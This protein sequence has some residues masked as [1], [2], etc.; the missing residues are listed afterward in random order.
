MDRK[1]LMVFADVTR[2]VTV[3]GLLFLN[4]TDRLWIAYAVPAVESALAS[5][6]EPASMAAIPN[7]VAPEDLATA[8]ALAGSAWGT[9]LAVGAALGAIVAATLG[10][11]AAF[12]ADS[13]SFVISAIL[14]SSIRTSLSEAATLG[15]E[16]IGVV[17]ATAETIRYA[18]EDHRVL[19]LIAVKGGFGL[20]GGVIVLL[21]VLGTKVFH[22]GDIGI[23][24]LM[25]AR[26][27]GALIG[28]FIGKRI[29][30]NEFGK[31]LFLAIGLALVTFGFFYML[32]PFAPS[33]ALAAVCAAGAHLGGGAQWSLSTFGLQKIVPD[34]IRGRVFAFDVALITLTITISSVVAG[35][36]AQVW[37]VRVAIGTIAVLAL[38]YAGLWWWATSRVRS[39]LE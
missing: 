9:M 10:S 24:V 34:R 20:A 5:F 7:L 33:L 29:A 2:A 15:E 12:I 39:A 1:K 30:G 11:N 38:V 31:R 28:P 23:G 32:I 18:R 19:S 22:D 27:I 4:G 35:I 14:L 37:G 3:L 25:S 21:S 17:E 26:G 8:N 13:L 36:V 16:R 6:F